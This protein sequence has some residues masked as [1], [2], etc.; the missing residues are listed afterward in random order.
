VPRRLTMVFKN[1]ESH[2]F[3]DVTCSSW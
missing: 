2:G 1:L 3:A